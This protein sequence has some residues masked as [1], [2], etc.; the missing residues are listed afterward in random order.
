M[1]NI[2][3]RNLVVAS[4]IYWKLKVSTFIKIRSDLTFLLY[5]V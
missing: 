2:S 4:T 1:D 3:Q 5:D